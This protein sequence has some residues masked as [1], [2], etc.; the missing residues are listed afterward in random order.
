MLPQLQ[1]C[2]RAAPFTRSEAKSAARDCDRCVF[3]IDLQ[4]LHRIVSGQMTGCNRGWSGKN[5]SLFY[6]ET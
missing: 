3:E 4:A 5:S 2:H 1:A 6:E